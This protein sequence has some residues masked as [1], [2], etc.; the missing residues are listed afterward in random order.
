MPP[1]WGWRAGPA[2]LNTPRG[3]ER[4]V[5]AGGG[6]GGGGGSGAGN[7]L[8]VVA[9]SRPYAL[10]LQTSQ[11]VVESINRLAQFLC[12]PQPAGQPSL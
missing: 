9:E 10:L 1:P 8:A 4:T 11:I 7:L 5:N 3:V 2:C 6:G 12:A